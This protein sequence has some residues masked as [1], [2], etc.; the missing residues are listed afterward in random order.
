MEI[1]EI[2]TQAEE[3][4]YCER[5]QDGGCSGAVTTV[6]MDKDEIKKK[7]PS[8]Y[9][10]DKAKDMLHRGCEI[11][12]I[13]KAINCRYGI[14]NDWAHRFYNRLKKEGSNMES[15]TMAEKTAKVRRCPAPK[16]DWEKVMEL[17][18]QGKTDK[19]I[20]EVIG[21]G[22][23]TLVMWRKN[24]NLPFNVTTAEKYASTEKSIATELVKLIG[25]SVGSDFKE[26]IDI[27][28][29]KDASFDCTELRREAM[30]TLEIL[31][32]IWEKIQ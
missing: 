31:K 1:S 25:Q 29:E 24:N 11:A 22:R 7:Y 4:I 23:S 21:C 9:D 15:I 12:E 28:D 32:S 18:R 2:N 5:K 13:A 26:T 30:L 14:V 19:E 20:C 17:Y 8:K 16:Y 6:Y 10:W 27:E 3:I